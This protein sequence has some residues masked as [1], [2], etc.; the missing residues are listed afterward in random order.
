MNSEICETIRKRILFLEYEPGQILNE[1][2]LAKEFGVS[3][4]PLREALSRLE[5]EK[6]VKILPR[7]GS[8]VTSVEFQKLRD[9]FQIRVSLEGLVARLAASLIS[10]EDLTEMKNICEECKSL[11][12]DR[13][14]QQLLHIDIKFR[15]VLN[16][17]AGN[18]ILKEISEYLYN[19]TFRVWYLVF[20]RVDW[21]SLVEAEMREIEETITILSHRDPQEAEAF[22]RNVIINYVERIKNKF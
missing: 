21:A 7:A 15:E 9:V 22:R 5:W 14:P 1:K 3:R 11:F 8:V 13:S 6:L 18:P 4:T 16:R 20:D 19:M 17:A 10:E 2:A 12:E